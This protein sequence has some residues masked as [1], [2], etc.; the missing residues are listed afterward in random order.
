MQQ[1]TFERLNHLI[2][3]WQEEAEKIGDSKPDE[4]AIRQGLILCKCARELNVTI[5]VLLAE[6]IK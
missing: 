2:N 5:S 1:L 6:E 4:I 3:K